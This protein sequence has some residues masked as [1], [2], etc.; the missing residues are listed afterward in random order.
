VR[1]KR[2]AAVRVAE[3]TTTLPSAPAGPVFLPLALLRRQVNQ[4]LITDIEDLRPFF[5]S[6]QG[7]G[8]VSFFPAFVPVYT[9]PAITPS[10]KLPEWRI[11]FSP[12][13]AGGSVPKFRA[14]KEQNEAATGVLPLLLPDGARLSAFSV[15]G[16]ISAIDGQVQW[17]V[18]RISYQVA[19]ALNASQLFDVLGESTSRAT[20][21]GYIFGTTSGFSAEESKLI[22]DNGRYYYALLARTFSTPAYGASIHGISISYKYFGLMG[23][24]THEHD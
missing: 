2:E 22:V 6:P 13:A 20:S 9:P 12:L 1:L 5:Y 10:V 19:T 3:G 23:E 7:T 14:V 4:A 21:A 18:L 8:V 17:Q 24:P 16:D 11:M 15:T